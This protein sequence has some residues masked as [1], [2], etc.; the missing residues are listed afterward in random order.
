MDFA[1]RHPGTWLHFVTFPALRV[2]RR[3]QF[4]GGQ[5]VDPRVAGMYDDPTIPSYA[6]GSSTYDPSFRA[7]LHLSRFDGREGRD[8]DLARTELLE[9]AARAGINGYSRIMISLEL[10]GRLP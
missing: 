7:E 6:T 2:P 10:L 9:S 5:V 8:V 3:L 4:G 1:I